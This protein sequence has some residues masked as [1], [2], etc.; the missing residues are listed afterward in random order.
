[1]LDLIVDKREFTIEAPKRYPCPIPLR[2][3]SQ[4]PRNTLITIYLYERGWTEQYHNFLLPMPWIVYEWAYVPQINK[5]RP[6]L[7]NSMYFSTVPLSESLNVSKPCLPNF[8]NTIPCCGEDVFVCQESFEDTDFVRDYWFEAFN[9]D[10]DLL[11]PNQEP[12][13]IWAHLAEKA[14]CPEYIS[15]SEIHSVFSYWESLTIDQLTSLNWPQ[16]LVIPEC[17]TRL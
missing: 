11:N 12:H 3:V 14:G 13:P 1:M 9:F 2:Y 4:P 7:L 15:A 8:Y 5:E 16:D 10:G 6:W 17:S